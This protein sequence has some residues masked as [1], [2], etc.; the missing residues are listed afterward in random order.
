MRN[1]WALCA[2][3]LLAVGCSSTDSTLVATS[4]I[5]ADLAAVA[6]GNGQTEVEAT[7][8]IGGPSSA[9]F[10]DLEGGDVLR[11]TR[12]N[13]SSGAELQET[14][15]ERQAFGVTWYTATFQTQDEDTGFRID[16][17]RDTEIS[18]PDS[19]VTLPATFDLSWD[20]Y[21][22]T[23]NAYVGPAIEPFSRTATEDYAVLVDD[24]G[25]FDSGDQLRYGVEGSCIETNQGPL[26]WDGNGE[27]SIT[28]SQSFLTD[29]QPAGQDCTL[30]VTITLLRQGSVDRA[31]GEGG[32]FV[33]T[34]VRTLTLDST[35]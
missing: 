33:A 3:P 2:I 28:L 7:L 16:F 29:S 23:T 31:F 30:T 19:N 12:I 20:E 10:V 18:A 21:H 17:D 11:A 34:Q 32:A 1:P 22:T 13:A 24:I 4:E 35:P 8:R 14:M 6:T 25:A 15:Q 26:N 9:R 5:Y 27:N